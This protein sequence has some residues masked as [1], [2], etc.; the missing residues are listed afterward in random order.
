MS[1]LDLKTINDFN[2]DDHQGT[3]KDAKGKEE[4][5]SSRVASQV[6]IEK[7]AGLDDINSADKVDTNTD[8]EKDIE[9][10]YM[11]GFKEEDSEDDFEK[12]LQMQ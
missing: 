2:F 11:E 4:K 7:V 5:K 12:M 6:N 8:E 10:V 3:D 9:D 1:K